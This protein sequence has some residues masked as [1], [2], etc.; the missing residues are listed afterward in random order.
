MRSLFRSTTIFIYLDSNTRK[1]TGNKIMMTRRDYIKTAE[2]LF[3]FQHAL[4]P[5]A[6]KMLVD[7]FSEMFENDNP[8]FNREIFEKATR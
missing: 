1:R 3:M 8:N 7:E 2:I 4:K 6:F 5:E